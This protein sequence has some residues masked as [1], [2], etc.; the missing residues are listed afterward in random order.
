MCVHAQGHLEEGGLAESD[1]MGSRSRLPTSQPGK[2]VGN[3]L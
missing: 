2:V 1:L 3:I